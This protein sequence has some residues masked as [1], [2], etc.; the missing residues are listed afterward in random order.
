MP[1]PIDSD[2]GFS[3]ALRQA[4]AE[5]GCP[6]DSEVYGRPRRSPRVDGYAAY[7][8]AFGDLAKLDAVYE[9]HPRGRVVGYLKCGASRVSKDWR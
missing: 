2:E 4:E 8:A 5:S 6:P 7:M 3:Q 1:H 9:P